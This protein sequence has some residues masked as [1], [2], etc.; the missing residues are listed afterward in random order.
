MKV[1]LSGDV[2]HRLITANTLDAFS[3]QETLQ[4]ISKFRGLIAPIGRVEFFMV[5][6][7]ER[8]LPDVCGG[9]ELLEVEKKLSNIIENLGI[10][11]VYI[12]ARDRRRVENLV[13]RQEGD[14]QFHHL[15]IATIATAIANNADHVITLTNTL[16]NI[17]QCLNWTEQLFPDPNQLP[18]KIR[19]RIQS[20]RDNDG[21]MLTFFD[22]PNYFWGELQNEHR[23]NLKTLLI[24]FPTVLLFVLAL[25]FL[26]CIKPPEQRL[27]EQSGNKESPVQPKDGNKIVMKKPQDLVSS[28][29]TR[30]YGS[31]KLSRDY[32]S[33]KAEGIIAFNNKDYPKAE[34]KFREIRSKAKAVLDKEEKDDARQAITDPEVLIY[35]NN[36][37]VRQRNDKIYTIVVAVPV[38]D[39]N[40]LAFERGRQI[41]FGVAQAQNAAV[42]HDNPSDPD[43][44]KISDLTKSKETPS[45]P[46]IIKMNLEVVIANDLNTPDQAYENANYLA[47]YKVGERKSSIVAVVGHYTSPVSCKALKVYNDKKIVLIS[48]T[49]TLTDIRKNPQCK[50]EEI[51]P[52]QEDSKFFFR[53]TV[54]TEDEASALVRYVNTKL[55]ANNKARVAVLYN[56][57]EGFSKNLHDQFQKKVKDSLDPSILGGDIVDLDLSK[58]EL[59]VSD[60]SQK[61]KNSQINILAVFPDGQTNSSESFNLAIRVLKEIDDSISI[62]LGAYTLYGEDV[63]KKIDAQKLSGKLAIAVDWTPLCENHKKSF[64]NKNA[65]NDIWF[66]KINGITALSYEAVQVLV[67]EF[68]ELN[69]KSSE[70]VTGESLQR[71]LNT[72]RSLYF[73]IPPSYFSDAFPKKTITFRNGNREEIRDRIIVTTSKDSKPTG[74]NFKLAEGQE[75]CSK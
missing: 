60:I 73:P 55:T 15:I 5:D 39:K 24:A 69:N 51:P 56:S 10:K 58:K 75:A 45:Q 22:E 65:V 29:E 64:V 62:V 33:L 42:N 26:F 68:A 40:G 14:R 67:A 23:K 44:N 7:V 3:L 74:D 27:P 71:Q 38:S 35:Q 66:G 16:T 31:Y 48:P 52:S 19:A 49:S 37:I 61:L 59:N 17:R 11:T 36:A 57:Q 32:E 18:K 1:F 21:Q 50:K 70:N 63:T 25:L 34:Q 12:T 72:S 41:L 13:Q 30:I 9:I 8:I 20:Q 53:T 4:K 2:I 43:P 54:S 47:D 6:E 28:G 46:N